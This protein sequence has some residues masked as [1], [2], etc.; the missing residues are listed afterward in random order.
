MVGRCYFWPTSATRR[1]AIAAP[2]LKVASFPL[3][4]GSPI[5][6]A[7][8]DR[9]ASELI[10]SPSP[11]E[12]DVSLEILLAAG[13]GKVRMAPDAMMEEIVSVRGQSDVARFML[14]RLKGL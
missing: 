3:T 11:G 7:G 10:L 13:L 14:E 1:S 8:Q 12:N 4:T 5:G 9:G 6:R 2:T